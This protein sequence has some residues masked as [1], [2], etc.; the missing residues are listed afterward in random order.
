VKQLAALVQKDP[1]VEIHI[2]GHSAGS[3]FMAPVVQMLTAKGALEGKTL[4]EETRFSWDPESTLASAA[5]AQGHGLTLKT[6]TLWA[7]ACTTGL[8]KAAYQPA[9]EARAAILAAARVL[10][11]PGGPTRTIGL[12]EGLRGRGLN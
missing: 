4:Q 2:A 12:V 11:A 10:P 5:A 7:P 8:F 6:C 3:I 9:I 1:G